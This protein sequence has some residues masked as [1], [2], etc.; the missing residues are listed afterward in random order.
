MWTRYKS[1][2]V[3]FIIRFYNGYYKIYVLVYIGWENELVRGTKL[4][5]RVP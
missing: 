1:F 4:V 5:F 2:F 3:S